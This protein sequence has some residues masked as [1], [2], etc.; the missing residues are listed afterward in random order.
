[1]TEE[2]RKSILANV[3]RIPPIQLAQLVLK[4]ELTLEELKTANL[5]SPRYKIV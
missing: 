5:A 1:M 2:D 4:K 3:N